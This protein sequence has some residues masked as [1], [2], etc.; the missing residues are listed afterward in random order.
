MDRHQ[1]PTGLDLE[2]MTGR[3]LR[4]LTPADFRA[5][6]VALLL[7]AEIPGEHYRR[8]ELTERAA[9]WARLATAPQE[10]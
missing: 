8:A 6:A 5:K 4:D 2:N 9:V 1:L 10:R 7:K 3:Q